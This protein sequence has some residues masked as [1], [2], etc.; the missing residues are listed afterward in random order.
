[1]YFDDLIIAASTVEEH[2]AILERVFQCARK[3]NAKFNKDK[4]QFRVRE[5]Q[6]AGQI[7]SKCGIRPDPSHVRAIVEM[8]VPEKKKDVLQ[9]LGMCNFVS[10]YIPNYSHLSSPLRKL[11]KNDSV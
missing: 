3:N 1:M 7:I 6:Y 9:F 11:L 10:K 2:D 5:V 8:K 4:V